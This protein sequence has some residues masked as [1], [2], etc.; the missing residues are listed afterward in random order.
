MKPYLLVIQIALLSCIMAAEFPKKRFIGDSIYYSSEI[1]QINYDIKFEKIQLNFGVT[2]AGKGA[3][4]F[5]TDGIFEQVKTGFLLKYNKI[6]RF[7]FFKPH[8]L[9]NIYI[10]LINN[11]VIKLFIMDEEM[12]AHLKTIDKAL[13]ENNVSSSI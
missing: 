13:N 8:K 10:Y 1:I 5:K 4:V 6:V 12:D 3:K 9:T 7:E 11:E 2:Q